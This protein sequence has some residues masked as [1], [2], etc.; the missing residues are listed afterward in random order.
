MNLQLT[1]E[2]NE[3]ISA[4]QTIMPFPPFIEAI[5]TNLL[6]AVATAPTL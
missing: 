3:V 6:T 5:S 4:Q 1:R 2:G